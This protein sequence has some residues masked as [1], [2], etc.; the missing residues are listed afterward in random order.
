[1]QDVVERLRE[2]LPPVFAVSEATHLTGGA[3]NSGTLRNKKSRG[4]IPEVCFVRSGAK[5]I[6]VRD[7]LLD[8]W[9]TTLKPACAPIDNPPPRSRR[10]TDRAA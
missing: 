4:E 5:L 2:G 9:S 7:P 3:I 1:M 6:A 8:W 10:Q